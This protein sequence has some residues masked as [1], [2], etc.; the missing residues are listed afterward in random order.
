M[1]PDERRNRRKGSERQRR[2]GVVRAPSPRRVTRPPPMHRLR[3]SLED[4]VRQFQ[5]S[6]LLLLAVMVSGTLGYHWIERLGWLDSAYMTVI[7]VA[8]VGFGEVRPLTPAGRVF[9]MGLILVGVGTGAWAATRAV[10]VMLGQT[11][12]LSVQRRRMRQ[13]LAG[14]RD[15]YVICGHGRLGTRIERDLRARGEPFVVIDW[16]EAIEE[17]FLAENIP[18]VIGD[19]TQDEVLRTAG[20]ERARGL[21]SALDSDASNVLAVLSARGLN[22]ELLIVA[23]ANSE[24]SEPKL[25]RAGADRV[26]TPDAIGGHRLALALLRPAVHDLF[27]E[28]FSFGVQIAIDVGQITIEPQ[29][30]FAGQTVAGCD[31]RRVR[32]VSIL[33]VREPGGGF[34]LN[35]D[36]E[37]VVAPGETLI[38][39]GP[40]EAVYELEA[41][42]SGD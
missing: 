23:R 2:L 35:P 34:V 12:W 32:N 38:V 8:T 22:P 18:H 19:A 25:R 39:I 15:H 37:R 11:L 1:P 21:V 4:P 28:I 16:E 31:L 13:S 5:A 29:S 10:E 26:V 42:Y 27:N 9:T 3:T 30:P 33:A 24:S 41:M 36:A 17:T 40:A 6:L 20:V 14:L 7:T